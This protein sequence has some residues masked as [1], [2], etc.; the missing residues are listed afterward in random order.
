M[1]ANG[2][3]VG[4]AVS[5][6]AVCTCGSFKTAPLTAP[7]ELNDTGELVVLA[8]LPHGYVGYMEGSQE[9]TPYTHSLMV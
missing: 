2:C 1:H 6:D 4:T 3:H 8:G 9:P 5:C 7:T